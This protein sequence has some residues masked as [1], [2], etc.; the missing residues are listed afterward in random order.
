MHTRADA[1]VESI[2]R[3]AMQAVAQLQVAE[4][5]RETSLTARAG[6]SEE[7]LTNVSSAVE[8]LLEDFQGRIEDSLQ[9]IQEKGARLAEDLEKSAKELGGRWSQQLQEQATAAVEKLREEAK[10]SRQVMEESKRQLVGLAEAK[11]A[12]LSQATQEEYGQQLAQTVREHAQVM[13][14]TGDAEVESI[15]RAA[16]QAVTQLRDTEQQRETSLMARAG[17]AEERLTDVSSAVEALQRRVGALLEDF[18]VRIEGTLQAVQEKGAKQAEDLEKITRILGGRWSQQLQEQATAAVERLRE[19]VKN[20][21]QVMEESKRQLASL[22]EEKLASLSQVGAKAVEG[23]EAE[24]LRLNE[25]YV[26]TRKEIEDLLEMDLTKPPTPFPRR[27]THPKRRGMVGPL[28]L[29]AAVCLIIGV[30]ILGL[31]RST[32]PEMQLQPEAPADFIDQSPNWNA[33]RR[34]REED[35]AQGYWRAAVVSLQQRYPFGSELPADP[36]T[37]FQVDDRY[38]PAGNAKIP[39]ETRAL[40][41][42]KLR[43]NWVQRQFWVHENEQNIPWAGRLLHIWNQVYSPK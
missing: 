1:E 31:H 32:G 12:S 38:V 17:V 19:E 30:P 21:G 13:R 23:L 18:Q 39:A 40:Y 11:L 7:R 34:A 28:A 6:A 20:S 22:T 3:A 35:V 16:L 14:A 8:A 29:V 42:G 10:N 43:R 24:Q 25:Q 5:Q 33:K 15:K 36:P 37:E 27:G 9:A 41:W 26:A 2:K 4:Q